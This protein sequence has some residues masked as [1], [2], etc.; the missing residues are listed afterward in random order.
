[1]QLMTVNDWITENYTNIRSWLFNITKGHRNELYEDFIH[2]VLLAFLQMPQA[3]Q[4]VDNGKARFL[5]ARI[6]LNMWRSRTSKWAK[7]EWHTME[8]ILDDFELVEELYTSED[9]VLLELII[10][11]LDEM[12][13]GDLTEYYMGLVIVISLELKGNFSEMSRRLDI[14][15]TSLNKVYKEGIKLIQD[16]LKIKML[17]LE[18]GTIQLSGNPNL[19]VE[20][21]A[22]LSST[23]KRKTLQAHS[24]AVRAGFFRGL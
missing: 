22:E 6:G 20:R 13:I 8:R 19:V 1:M 10:G 24:E 11:I 23:A 7:Q 2:E 15:R 16:R 12:L 18:N 14:P 5:L 21:W 17:Q 4:A 9:D 3:Q